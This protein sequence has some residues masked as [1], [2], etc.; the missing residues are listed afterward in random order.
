M[1][2]GIASVKYT[3]TRTL[4]ILNDQEEI[5]SLLGKIKNYFEEKKRER[6]I[7]EQVLKFEQEKIRKEYWAKKEEQ[8]MKAEMENEKPQEE[9]LLEELQKRGVNEAVAS[10]YLKLG[11]K[12]ILSETMVGHLTALECW[13]D[14]RKFIIMC[15]KCSHPLAWRKEKWSNGQIYKRIRC[16]NCNWSGIADIPFDTD[17]LVGY[18]GLYDSTGNKL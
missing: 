10:A 8:A 13:C 15:I 9:D 12:K 16:P 2:G 18:E 6:E 1:R 11:I 4:Y 17:R 3:G 5:M 14:D 7:D